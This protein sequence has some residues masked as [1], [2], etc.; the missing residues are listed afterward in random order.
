MFMTIL[1]RGVNM[2]EVDSSGFTALM[3]AALTGR[4]HNAQLLLK[5]AND[6][7]WKY[8]DLW[9]EQYYT[10]MDLWWGQ[11]GVLWI[12]GN[13]IDWGK[14]GVNIVAKDP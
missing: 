5:T 1:Y 3:T 11:Y 14:A 10:N 6:S 2:D 7:K 9:W 4:A 8:I 12:R 13:N